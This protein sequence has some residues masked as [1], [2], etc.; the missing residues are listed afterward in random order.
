MNFDIKM[1]QRVQFFKNGQENG[2]C[3]VFL[4]FHVFLGKKTCFSVSQ[5]RTAEALPIRSFSCW[6]SF[7]FS[8]LLQ[9]LQII[10]PQRHRD[11]L[12]SQ[13]DFCQNHRGPTSKER[14]RPFGAKNSQRLEL[15]YVILIF[16]I[17]SSISIQ[18]SEY[19]VLCLHAIKQVLG[20]L[21]KIGRRKGRSKLLLLFDFL[22]LVYGGGPLMLKTGMIFAFVLI[23]F[24]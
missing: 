7:C 24:F 22:C 21:G 16:G 15:R 11:L 23:T 17:G 12:L 10:L 6:A 18:F 19:R 8:A 1:F 13:E 20:V 2:F 9:H 5:R 4:V 3:C 14:K